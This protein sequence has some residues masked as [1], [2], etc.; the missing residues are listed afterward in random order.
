MAGWYVHTFR[1]VGNQPVIGDTMLAYIVVS[2]LQDFINMKLAP[3][4]IKREFAGKCEVLR[5]FAPT[6]KNPRV[7]SDNDEMYIVR[8]VTWE[9]VGFIRGALL[10]IVKP[11][12]EEVLK[13]LEFRRKVLESDKIDPSRLIKVLKFAYNKR[14]KT[15]KYLHTSV[16][17][18]TE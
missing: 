1:S 10:S 15:V 5:V 16:E 2:P 11:C 3:E 18:V 17:E 7:F 13:L 4:Q 9:P 12:D 6:D 14:M 8:S